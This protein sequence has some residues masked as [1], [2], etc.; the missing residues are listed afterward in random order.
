M[1]YGE[2]PSY[3]S[4]TTFDGRIDSFYTITDASLVAAVSA[5]IK[6]AYTLTCGRRPEGTCG[7]DTGVSCF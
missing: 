3:G 5:F 1:E 4:T 2:T 7:G 6:P